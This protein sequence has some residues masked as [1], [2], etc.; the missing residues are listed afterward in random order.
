M[1]HCII[2]YSD[3]LERQLS[4]D[5]L[6]HCVYLGA[7]NSKL[8]EADDIKSRVIPFQHFTSGTIKQNFIHVALK[9]LSGRS[10]EQR[11]ALSSSVLTELSKLPLSAISLTVEVIEIERSSYSK[12][13]N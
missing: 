11:K 10:S 7:L 6:M 8:F 9:I 5:E 4:P 2:E 1:P 3:S 13:V 12:V